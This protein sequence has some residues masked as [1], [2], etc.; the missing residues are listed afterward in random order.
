MFV[1]VVHK[2]YLPS[3]AAQE[4]EVIM[5]LRAVMALRTKRLLV[6]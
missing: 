3:N 1:P 5:N 6:P 4:Q 2:H